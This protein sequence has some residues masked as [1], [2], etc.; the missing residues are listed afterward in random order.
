MTALVPQPLGPQRSR[1]LPH[2]QDWTWSQSWRDVLFVHWEAD[3]RRLREYLPAELEPDCW[4]GSNW[5][6]AVAFRLADVRLR[7]LPP[8]PLCTDFLELNLRTY[9]RYQGEPGIYFLRMYAD[10]RVAVAAAR[11][12]TPLPYCYAPMICRREGGVWHLE[13]GNR[14][15]GPAALLA[16]QF[17]LQG[18]A[19]PAAE[20]SLDAWLVERYLAFVPDRRGR[21]HRMKVAHP[22]WEIVPMSADVQ[23]A[24]CAEPFGVE[25]NSPPSG[26]H[27][28]MGVDS[29]VA[30]FEPACRET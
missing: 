14:S 5:V 7:G 8:I 10:S 6:S 3:G 22:P 19:Q 12:L 26:C 24:G 11:W 17:Q 4:H 25:R 29:L 27:F 21:L 16:G 15:A 23:G 30:P 9:V 20:N 2:Q 13:C 18:S 1:V 28:S